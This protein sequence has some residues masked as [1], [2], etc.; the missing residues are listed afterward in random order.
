MRKIL[1]IAWK[2]IYLTFTDRSLLVIMILTPLLL[3]SIIGLA[4]GGQS[5]GTGSFGDIPIAIVNLD[6][7]TDST[8]QAFDYGQLFVDI[9]VSE[10]SELSN[11]TNSQT[12]E[13]AN[14]ND[15]DDGSGATLQDLFNTTVL[16]DPDAARMAV[17]NGEYA[18]AIII[19]S[20][21]SS[22]LTPT[23]GATGGSLGNTSV[24]VYGNSGAPISSGITRSVTESITEQFATG[25]TTITITISELILQAQQDIRVA[26][27]MVAALTTGDVN[28]DFSCAFV[29]TSPTIQ[30][31]RQTVDFQD[32]SQ[33]VL[34][35]VVIGSA[36]SI[37]SSMFTAQFGVLSVYNERE[38]GTLQRMVVTPTSRAEIL[39]GKVLGVFITVLFQLVLL[40]LSLT[41]VAT[42]VEGEPMFIWG[43]NYIA[44]T[45]VILSLVLSVCGIG[46]LLAGIANS[47][48]QARIVGPMLNVAM[49]A[50]GGAFGFVL[51][52]SVAQF[53]NIYWA[54]DAFRVLASG[55]G[56]IWL[57]VAVLAIQGSI[58]TVAGW[59]LFSR[60]AQI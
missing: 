2:D 33:F 52:A 28:L 49:G 39:F 26:I 25:A 13:T 5:S 31:E 36:Q 19:P 50:L 20:D 27:P 18:A 46:I 48:E 41:I 35:L 56:D 11:T 21:F 57:N 9:L 47:A 23:F 29:Q 58:M 14:D 44:L 34:V 8:Q 7:G 43:S 6:E 38:Q 60:R 24:E 32:I 15:T 53:S 40:M 59:W 42:L 30:V 1:T 4:F 16:D 37:F 12:C 51:P 10:T 17:A 45:A 22:K 3:S 54:S 55:G